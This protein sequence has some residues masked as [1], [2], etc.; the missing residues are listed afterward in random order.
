M[1]TAKEKADNPVGTA[2][3]NTGIFMQ[4]KSNILNRL[5]CINCS[6]RKVYLKDE[7]F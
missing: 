5:P 2:H 1:E 3:A 6:S 4:L 7:I